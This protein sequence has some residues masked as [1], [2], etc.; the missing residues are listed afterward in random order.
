MNMNFN[1]F[2]PTHLIFGTGK[3]NELGKQ[4]MPGKKA[5]LLLS[6]GKSARISGA[7]DR[8]QQQLDSAGVSYVTCANIHENPSKDVVM[9]AATTARE[10]SCDFIVALGGGSVIDSAKA[11]AVMA[12]KTIIFFISQR[13]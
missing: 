10:N 5:L 11:I 13:I 6:N 4:K 8:T 1:F 12:S 3:L 7:L 2:T 9:Q